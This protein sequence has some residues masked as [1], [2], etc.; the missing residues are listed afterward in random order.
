MYLII[1]INIIKNIKIIY[2][3][4]IINIDIVNIN[5]IVKNIYINNNIE[6]TYGYRFV[7]KVKFTYG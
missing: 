1:I 3:L 4:N 7:D 6:F 5:D 2:I